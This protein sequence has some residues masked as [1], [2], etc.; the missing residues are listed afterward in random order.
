LHCCS[1]GFPLLLG[2]MNYHVKT[3]ECGSEDGVRQQFLYYPSV[4]RW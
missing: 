1:C 3:L 2:P 4:T